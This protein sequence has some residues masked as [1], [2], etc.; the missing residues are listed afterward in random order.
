MGPWD[1]MSEHFVERRQPPPGI[2]SFTKIR[3]GWIG[4]EQVLLV[5][6]GETAMTFLSPLSRKGEK[7]VVKIPLKGDRYYLIENRQPVGFDRILPDSGILI[8]K[9]DPN[10]AEG[11]GTVKVVDANPNAR[12]F[13]QAT[14]RIE[15]DNR[16]L[17][18]DDHYKIAVLPL[19]SEKGEM[20]VL[21]TT[22][23]KSSAARDAAVMIRTLLTRYPEPRGESQKQRVED[24]IAAFKKFAFDDCMQKAREANLLEN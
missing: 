7:L 12:H 19:W 10:A 11:S 15:Q 23:E 17:Y 24:C 4:L 5:T 13:S 20:G 8:L 3:L 16:N 1:I 22:P 18:L 2:S 6:P 9:V 21:V 14:F